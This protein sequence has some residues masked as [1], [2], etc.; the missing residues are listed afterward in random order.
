[1]KIGYIGLGKMGKNMVLHLLE[2]DV[3]IV[4]WNR[5]P[6][7]R[8]EVAQ[9]GATSVESLEELVASLEAPRIIWVMLTAGDVTD[10]ILNQLAP[11]LSEGDLVV[12]GGNSLYTD[13]LRRAKML[14]EKGIHFMDIGTSGGP[15]GARSGA[16]MMIGGLEED[17]ERVKEIVVKGSAPN[18]Y[19]HL[20][21]VG[22]GHFAKM[23][24]NGV[25]YGMM[26]A[27]AEGVAILDASQF[28]YDLAQVFE[29]YQQQSVITSRLVGWMQEA[30]GEDPN[31]ESY[32][33]V[34]GHTGEGAWTV[35]AAEELGVDAPVIK[36][37]L[38][39]RTKSEH[40]P[41]SIRNRAVSAMRGKFGG[42]SVK[43]S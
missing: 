34:I 26:Q 4:A 16:C 9:A 23:I 1:M 8:E 11:L 38:R 13:T 30:L 40:E 29:L 39:V 42:H 31:L 20:G 12:D 15:G 24:H 6:A 25:E 33:S 22:A 21:P 27:I 2:Q 28:D 37:S 35:R 32:S 3:E 19:A 18:A 17:F 41:D 36:E 43:R 5:S 7:P 14:R 10:E